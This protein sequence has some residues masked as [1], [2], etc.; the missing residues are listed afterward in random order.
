[1]CA[2]TNYARNEPIF[3]EGTV[4]DCLYKIESGCVRTY[5]TPDAGTRQL[6]QR[7]QVPVF[8]GIGDDVDLDR[9]SGRGVTIHPGCRVRGAGDVREDRLV[10]GDGGDRRIGPVEAPGDAH[11]ARRRR[12]VPRGRARGRP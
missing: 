6:V 2:P 9:I 11:D 3:T 5:K 8:D 12:T 10:H 1:M 4:A 7:S